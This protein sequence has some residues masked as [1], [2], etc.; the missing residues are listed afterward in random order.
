MRSPYESVV[1][2]V[3]RATDVLGHVRAD[4]SGLP[5]PCAAWDVRQVADHV[6][7]VMAA[8]AL[9]GR[10]EPVPDDH[11]SRPVANDLEADADAAVAAWADADA[12][13][14]PVRMGGAE[15]PG[16]MAAAMLASDLVIHGWDLARATGQ[17]YSCEEATADL[18]RQFLIDTGD[19]GRAMG[20]YAAAVPVG[21][22]ASILDQALAISGRDPQWTADRIVRSGG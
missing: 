22:D 11:W 6:A 19:Q 15:L 7:Q 5:T 10:G 21:A 12:W 8:L 16:A 14:R 17:P 4:Q 9:A 13:P 18:T 2:A 3:R 20:I 1:D